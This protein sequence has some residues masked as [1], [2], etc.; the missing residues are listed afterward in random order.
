MFILQKE[1]SQR[2]CRKNVRAWLL[3]LP[4]PCWGVAVL[5]ATGS[6]MP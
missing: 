1:L 3:M 5:E 4:R 6:S 2:F